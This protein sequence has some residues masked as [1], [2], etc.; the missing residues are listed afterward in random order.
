MKLILKSEGGFAG[1]SA[2]ATFDTADLPEELA[3]RVKEHL[4]SDTLRSATAS[5]SLPMPDAQQYEIQLLPESDDGEVEK[6]VVDDMCPIGE[7]L[8]VID[9]LMA[10]L[11]KRRQE[12]QEP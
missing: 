6:L 11:R 5:R 2:E 8:D 9:D 10:E 12:S 1:L 7:V 4:S 3:R